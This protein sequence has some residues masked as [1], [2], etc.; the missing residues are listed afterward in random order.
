MVVASRTRLPRDCLVHH[1]HKS[2]DFLNGLKTSTLFIY[3]APS[4]LPSLPLLLPKTYPFSSILARTFTY[5]IANLLVHTVHTLYPSHQ[6]L[7]S[8]S[9]CNISP[10]HQRTLCKFSSSLPC[11]PFMLTP[12]SQCTRICNTSSLYHLE[13]RAVSALFSH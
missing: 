4:P 7:P 12:N 1:V 13:A 6:L 2:P 11:L 10:T 5:I 3:P 8:S 9:I